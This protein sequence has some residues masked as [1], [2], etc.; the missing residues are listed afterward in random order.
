MVCIGVSIPYFTAVLVPEL[1]P[2]KLAA[3]ATVNAASV[4]S[5]AVLSCPTVPNPVAFQSAAKAYVIAAVSEAV[6]LSDPLSVSGA[7]LLA[8]LNYLNTIL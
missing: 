8:M 4:A 2:A 1:T 3:I 5:G 7:D 6:L